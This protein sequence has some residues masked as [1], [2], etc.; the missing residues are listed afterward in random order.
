MQTTNHTKERY[1]LYSEDIW[2][3]IKR[4]GVGRVREKG[5]GVRIRMKGKN[6]NKAGRGFYNDDNGNKLK[7]MINLI[8]FT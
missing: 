5:I 3:Y 7:N 6:E 2:V 4:V 8:S 1:N